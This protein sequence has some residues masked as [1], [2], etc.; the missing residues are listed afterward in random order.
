[1][2]QLHDDGYQFIGDNAINKLSISE[3][4]V[5]KEGQYQNQQERKRQQRAQQSADGD[6]SKTRMDIERSRDKNDKAL[7]E[8]MASE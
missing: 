3:V 1:M 7:V 6:V 8:E 5:L 2:A 4:R